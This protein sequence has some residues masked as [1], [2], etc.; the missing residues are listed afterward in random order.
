VFDEN[1]SSLG[2]K[3]VHNLIRQLNGEIEIKKGTGTE[4]IIIFPPAD[5]KQRV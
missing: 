3:I 1:N 4:F 2:M 5:Y